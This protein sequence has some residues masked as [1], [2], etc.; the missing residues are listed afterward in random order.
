MGDFSFEGVLFLAVSLVVSYF[1]Y[2]EIRI[3]I[4]YYKDDKE[5]REDPMMRCYSCEAV[6]SKMARYCPECGHDYGESHW[7]V[8]STR[9]IIRNIVILTIISCVALLFSISYFY[10]IIPNS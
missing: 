3:L 2:M 9:A 7:E 5:E 8:Y 10:E 4:Y 6:I 1:L